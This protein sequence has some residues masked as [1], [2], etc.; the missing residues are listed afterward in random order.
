MNHEEAFTRAERA[1][2]NAWRVATPPDDFVTRVLAR[3]ALATVRDLPAANA[4]NAGPAPGG[5]DAANR[6]RRISDRAIPTG[7]ATSLPAVAA[8]AVFLVLLGGLWSLRGGGPAGP[9]GAP[10][11]GQSPAAQ[12]AVW[13]VPN[14][15]DAG[16]RP[17]AAE[18]QPPDD[19]VQA[20]AS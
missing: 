18:V 3:A 16:P 13:G 7:P 8:A 17:E 2:L 15:H 14:D 1:A 6:G 5:A 10:E 20:S 9:K 19:G 11:P 4:V 12:R